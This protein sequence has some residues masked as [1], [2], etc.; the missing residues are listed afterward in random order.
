MSQN[1]Q[2]LLALLTKVLDVDA[3][4][5]SDDTS[6]DNTPSWDSFTALFLVSELETEFDVH[7]A[8]E[9]VYAVKCVRDIRTALQRHGVSFND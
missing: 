6:P 3:G 9:E 1:D 2:K 7:F 8:M 4:S 5:I